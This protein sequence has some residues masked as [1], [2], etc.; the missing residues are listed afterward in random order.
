MFEIHALRIVIFIAE[1]L[2]RIRYLDLL[3]VSSA[4]AKH[5]PPVPEEIYNLKGTALIINRYI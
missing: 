1:G 5:V 3:D 4:T 2:L